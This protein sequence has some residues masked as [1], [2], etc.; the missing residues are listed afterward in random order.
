MYL[1][2]CASRLSSMKVI[3]ST[4][5]VAAALTVAPVT[6]AIAA[7][8]TTVAV[9]GSQVRVN[10]APTG[11]ALEY[12]AGSYAPGVDTY[13]QVRSLTIDPVVAGAGCT[14][15][16]DGWVT[17]GNHTQSS[18]Y[19]SAAT[20]AD[21]TI[22][23]TPGGNVNLQNVQMYF[24]SGSDVIITG[25][26]NNYISAGDGA[27]Y[28]DG[29][30]G[31][32]QVYAG[33]GDDLVR[34]GSEAD[35]ISVGEGTNLVDGGAG[36]DQIFASGGNDV[37]NGGQDA[38]YISASNGDN[39]L[40]GGSGSDQVFSGNGADVIFDHDG[41]GD[42]INCG[43]GPDTAHSDAGPDLLNGC[44]SAPTGA[45]D[46]TIPTITIGAPTGGQHVP[47][48]SLIPASVTCA[49]AGGASLLSC[50]APP[51]ILGGRGNA[52]FVAA[53]ADRAA[54][55]RFQTVRYVVDLGPLPVTPQPGPVAPV[56][57]SRGGSGGPSTPAPGAKPLIDRRLPHVQPGRLT[58]GR[59]ARAALGRWRPRRSFGLRYQWQVCDDQGSNCADLPGATGRSVLVTTATAGKRVRFTVTAKVRNGVPVSTTSQLSSVVLGTTPVNR[60][61]PRIGGRAR[62]GSLLV[63]KKG[64]WTKVGGV[65]YTY[66]WQRCDA[67]GGACVPTPGA[68][69][70]LYRVTDADVGHTLVVK[71]TA[72]S[73]RDRTSA[74]AT[75]GPSAVIGA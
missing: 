65:R 69:R 18:L 10:S 40:S 52:M 23:F 48:G 54:N 25:P 66:E 8:L 20:A 2:D 71:V 37:L 1:R 22:L 21:N 64:T 5:I 43:D 19:I 44:E 11:L 58:T 75:S 49:D 3:G 55:L 15:G 12:A 28:V 39:T 61:R 36:G 67:S 68:T 27:N 14:N 16:I 72:T 29:G 35:Y 70:I 32:D 56:V 60:I 30:P 73:V 6:S 51:S 74:E 34:G 62:I 45:T 4:L 57:P 7:P 24:G 53:A 42:Y 41:A 63:A 9:S 38:D 50:V 13:V 31:T 33:S 46:T 47:E 17:C 59:R 26:E